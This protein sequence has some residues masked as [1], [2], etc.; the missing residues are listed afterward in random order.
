[1]DRIRIL[2]IGTVLMFALTT[3]AQQTTTSQ[4]QQSQQGAQ[5]GATAAEQHLKMLTEKLDLTSDQQAKAKPMIEQ[6]LDTRQKILQDGSMSSE[7]RSEQLR[8][9]HQKADKQLREILNDDQKKK[10]DQL[11][12]ERHG[13]GSATQQAPQN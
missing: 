12:Q 3:V 8:A 11:E 5:A 9:L 2:T 1:M 13:N 7:E 6:M 4:D 10:L